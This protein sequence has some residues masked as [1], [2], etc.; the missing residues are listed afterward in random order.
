M[1]VVVRFVEQNAMRKAGPASEHVQGRQDGANILQ[2][3]V[4]RQTRKVDHHAAIGIPEGAQQFA[5]RGRRVF[6]SEDGHPGQAFE[7]AVVP[8]RIDGADAVPMENQLL[9]EETRDPGLAGF[10]ASP[11]TSTFRPRAASANSRPSSRCLLFGRLSKWPAR[12][13]G[14]GTKSNTHSRLG[15][16]WPSPTACLVP[17]FLSSLSSLDGR[18]YNT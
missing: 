12:A 10:L 1:Q 5:G 14:C 9:A 13:F 4:V 2:L 18:R 16:G 7:R 3:F 15:R 6:A 11:V 17:S 8:F